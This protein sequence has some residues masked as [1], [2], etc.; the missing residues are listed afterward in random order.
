L[1]ERDN[2]L[3]NLKEFI[4]KM[5]PEWVKQHSSVNIKDCEDCKKK[6]GKMSDMEI[7]IKELTD[8]IKHST[9]KKKHEPKQ[10]IQNMQDP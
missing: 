5:D 7:R 3:R 8:Y 2:E 4:E 1:R 9:E 6:E 10:H